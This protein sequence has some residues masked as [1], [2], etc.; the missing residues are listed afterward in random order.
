MSQNKKEKKPEIDWDKKKILL[1]AI[2]LV[3]LLIVS[4]NVKSRI[5]GEVHAPAPKTKVDLPQVKGI[6]TQDISNN[7]KQA[8]DNLKTE[9]NNL[10]VAEV[11][12]SSPQVQ[13]ILN[14][15]KSL[16]DLP[17]NEIKNVCD[18][19]CNKL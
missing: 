6:S 4:I 11:A 13:K 2:G 3:L 16:Q 15:L 17:K 7:V 14:D 12:S 9:A 1:F 10:D 8:I 5:L 18:N 19:I